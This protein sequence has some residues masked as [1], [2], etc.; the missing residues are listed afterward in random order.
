MPAHDA[1]SFI[2]AAPSVIN[3]GNLGLIIVL[4]MIANFAIRKPQESQKQQM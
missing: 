2:N 1:I 3:Y 4:A